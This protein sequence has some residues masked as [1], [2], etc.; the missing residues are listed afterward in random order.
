[1]KA[2]SPKSDRLREQREQIAQRGTRSLVN[3]RLAPSPA[4]IKRIADRAEGKKHKPMK[5]AK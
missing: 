5:T 2:P 1:M 4:E 3:P